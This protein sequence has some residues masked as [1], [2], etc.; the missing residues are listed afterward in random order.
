MNEPD[1]SNRPSEPATQTGS[2]FQAPEALIS[3]II[4]GFVGLG[5]ILLLLRASDIEWTWK[6]WGSSDGNFDRSVI[7]RNFGLLILALIAL[8]LAVWRSWVAHQQARIANKQHLLSEK[9]LIIDRFQRGAQMLESD[10]LS[11]RLAGIYALRELVKSDPNET[12][13]M[14]QDLLFDFVRERS[15]AR[16]PDKNKEYPAFP[17]DLQKALEAASVL[18]ECTPL[19]TEMESLANWK[20]NLEHANLARV[21]LSELNLF[22]A[23]LYRANLCK[24]LIY[25]TDLTNAALIRVNMSH[26]SMSEA[27]LIGAELRSINF[28]EAVLF[29]VNF[30]DCRLSIINLSGAYVFKPILNNSKFHALWAFKDN[31]PEPTTDDFTAEIVTRNTDEAWETFIN[32]MINERPDLRWSIRMRSFEP[33]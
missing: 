21:S 14:V 4:L 7:F 2:A 5:L 32:R 22:N 6:Y 23:I 12:Y 8:P 25:N 29:N 17:P 24:A 18:R 28:S 15:K 11:V 33:I 19:G 27:K 16:A 10:E 3:G 30:S 31:P 26:V 20:P 1:S 9:G 13:I